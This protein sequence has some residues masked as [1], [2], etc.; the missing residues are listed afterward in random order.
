M[1]MIRDRFG[2]GLKLVVRVSGWW[3]VVGLS[4]GLG[5]GL[6]LVVRVQVNVND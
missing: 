4:L 3:L 2:Y 1:V 6:E 5:L